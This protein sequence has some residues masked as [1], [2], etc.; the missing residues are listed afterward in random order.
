MSAKLFIAPISCLILLSVPLQ[1]LAQFDNFLIPDDMLIESAE[2]NLEPE[3]NL[4][5]LDLYWSA[6]TYV[7]FGYQGRPLPTKE[8]WVKIGADLKVSG[9]NPKNLKYSWFLDGIFQEAKSGYGKDSFEFGVRRTSGAS[10]AVLLKVFN[11]SRS[12]LVEK[13]ISIPITNPELVVYHKNNAP[14]NL[15]YLSS[16]KSFDV[17]SDKEAAFLA[18]P[19]FFSIKSLKDLEFQWTLG[20]KSAKDSSLMANIFGLKIINKQV[21]GLVKDVLKVLVS[22]KRRPNQRIQK[23]IPINVY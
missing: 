23:T 8:S 11:E 22:N 3:I 7:P 16:E 12:F 18:L 21:G 14:L 9:G 1:I 13:S 4:Q 5:A 10:H 15:P 2:S 6:D 19:Y 17:V 20:D